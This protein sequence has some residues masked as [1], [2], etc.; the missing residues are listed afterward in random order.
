M[1]RAGRKRDATFQWNHALTFSFDSTKSGGP[2]W[3]ATESDG[4]TSTAGAMPEGAR[5]QPAP[6]SL[7]RSQGVE[8]DPVSGV[9]S[10]AV[11]GDHAVAGAEVEA[12]QTR[13]ILPAKNSV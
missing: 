6:Q 1:P 3:P 13:G 9:A 11:G 5:L 2:V 10:R 8:V 4:R 7:G 12:A